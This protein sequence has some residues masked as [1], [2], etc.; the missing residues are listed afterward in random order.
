MILHFFSNIH[1][2]TNAALWYYICTNS[3]FL[4]P[5]IQQALVCTTSWMQLPSVVSNVKSRATHCCEIKSGCVN[6]EQGNICLYGTF[7]SPTS[8][9]AFDSGICLNDNALCIANDVG[10]ER[11]T[12]CKQMTDDRHWLNV[13]WA[14]LWRFCQSTMIDRKGGLALV[15]AFFFSHDN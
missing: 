2:R 15:E 13:T 10:I 6:L 7:Y 1:W 14:Q 9:L 4:H 11:L 12:Y 3:H 8:E 5:I